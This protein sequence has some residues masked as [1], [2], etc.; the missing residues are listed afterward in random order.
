MLIVCPSCSASYRLSD[1][2][3]GAQGRS[4]RCGRC[5]QSWFVEP[6]ATADQTPT[7]PLEAAADVDW[8]EPDAASGSGGGALP[9]ADG[10]DPAAPVVAAEVP[11]A[12]ATIRI[13]PPPRRRR[14]IPKPSFGVML[15]GFAILVL[16]SGVVWR[17]QV[18][19]ALPQMAGLFELLR[20]PVNLRGLAFRD[21][22]TVEVIDNGT[23]V[24]VVAGTIDNIAHRPVAVPRLRLAVRAGKG[25]EIYVWT[26]VPAKTRLG[27][28]ESLPFR[29]Q[30]AAP[31]AEGV[32]VGV[33]FLNRRDAAGHLAQAGTS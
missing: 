29:A 14:P 10:R 26:A 5:G 9:V 32:E 18:V 25:R 11:E 30:L 8:S 24:L 3:V 12:A 33:R 21:V 17:R 23:P 20:L 1:E 31:P 13:R 16:A 7:G 15:V 2:E 28:G 22:S 4:V 19:S 27:A 6:E